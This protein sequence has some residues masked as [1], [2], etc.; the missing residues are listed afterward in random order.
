MKKKQSKKEIKRS[1]EN[2]MTK[3]WLEQKADK[4]Y[5]QNKS[6]NIKN[7]RIYK[8]GEEIVRTNSVAKIEENL[9]QVKSKSKENEVHMVENDKCDCLGFRFN[10]NCSHVVAVNIW[11][12]QNE[13]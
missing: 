10:Q 1:R 11:K 13:N 12:K 6:D 3:R 5:R 2:V 7:S 9:F 8:K 4:K